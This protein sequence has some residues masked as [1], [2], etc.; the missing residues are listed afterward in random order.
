M[1]PIQLPLDQPET[2]CLG[3]IF[4]NLFS[5]QQPEQNFNNE[6]FIYSPVNP[7]EQ[8]PCYED[9]VKVIYIY[10]HDKI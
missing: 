2:S 10:F 1:A 4:S 8:L 7:M 6:K 5:K 3:N 9:C